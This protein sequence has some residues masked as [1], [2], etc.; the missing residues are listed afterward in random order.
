VL[1]D[2]W[3][4][5][6]T[7]PSNP[8]LGIPVTNRLF[9][10]TRVEVPRL[11][12]EFSAVHGGCVSGVMKITIDFLITHKSNKNNRNNRNKSREKTADN[13]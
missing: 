7:P 11:G 6:P 1:A 8:Y 2:L 5:S 3:P 9:D 4:P 12:V 13:E 10:V